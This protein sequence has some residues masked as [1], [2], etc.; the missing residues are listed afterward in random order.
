MTEAAQAMNVGKSTMDKWVRQLRE[1][2]QGKTPKASPMTP[3]QIEIRE[4]KKKLARLEEHNEILKKATALLM[5]DSL[6][7]S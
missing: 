2:R 1:E 5:S 7:N 3:E 6:N 4:L